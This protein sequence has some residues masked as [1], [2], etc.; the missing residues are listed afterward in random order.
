M[1]FFNDNLYIGYNNSP[2]NFVLKYEL[3]WSIT[4]GTNVNNTYTINGLNNC[5]ILYVKTT[6]NTNGDGTGGVYLNDIYLFSTH[7]TGTSWIRYT[8][9]II[10]NGQYLY[11]YD[12]NSDHWEQSDISSNTV[13][14]KTL[15]GTDSASITINSLFFT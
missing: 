6:L 2:V 3:L 13:T 9:G 8:I 14:V 11:L 10:Y 5:L 12:I 4:V 1:L 15:Q 7:F